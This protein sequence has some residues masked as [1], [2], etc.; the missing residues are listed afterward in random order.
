M[1]AS[2]NFYSIPRSPLPPMT[3]G[4]MEST[5]PITEEKKVSKDKLRLIL[6]N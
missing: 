3:D 6:I 2:G 5:P 1:G 4:D